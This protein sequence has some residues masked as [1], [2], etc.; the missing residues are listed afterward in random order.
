MQRTFGLHS[1]CKL[2]DTGGKFIALFPNIAKLTTQ[3]EQFDQDQQTWFRKKFKGMVTMGFSCSTILG[4][5]DFKLGNFQSKLDEVNWAI[6]NSK[7]R[8][9]NKTF[10]SLGVIIEDGYEQAELGNCALCG[11]NA[12]DNESNRRYNQKEGADLPICRD[13]CDQILFFG[14]KLPRTNFL[15]FGKSGTVPVYRDIHLTLLE[16]A[17]DNNTGHTLHVDALNDVP[18]FSRFRLARHLPVLSENDFSDEK[19]FKLFEQDMDLNSPDWN[20]VPMTFSMIARKS[21]KP[22]LEKLI[23]RELLGFLKADVDNL[24]LLFSLGLGDRLSVARFSTLSRMLNLFFSEYLVEIVKKLFPYIYVVFAGGDDLFL[25]GP[26]WH[27]IQFALELR[28]Q[29]SKFCA[30]NGDITL[31]CGINTARPRLPMRKAAEL[32]EYML[33]KAK[34]V[35]T[36]DRLKNSICFQ[37]EAMPWSELKSLMALGDKLDRAVEERDRTN[38]STAFLYRLMAYQKMY[39]SFTQDKDIRAGRYLAL[40]HYDIGR[41]IKS[42]KLNNEDELSMLYRIF[43]VGT[44]ERPELSR[45]NVALF[46]A[47]NMNRED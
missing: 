25:V 40:A 35:D 42:P 2:L 21:K 34:E 16:K 3:L 36:P 13:C 45:L 5:E 23:G 28:R 17:P 19:W 11:I 10:S 6:E 33:D 43:A 1:V 20:Q 9:L 47:I 41:N 22:T 37:G 44:S 39:R 27:T 12:A 18:G 30:E 14:T 7:H 32:V 8:K 38:F 29:F 15:A 24:G 26:W 31:S 46:Y 4:Q